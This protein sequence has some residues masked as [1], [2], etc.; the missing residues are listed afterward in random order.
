MSL[1]FL[2]NAC[3]A[4]F[5][6]NQTV[7]AINNVSHILVPELVVLEQNGNGN[8]AANGCEDGVGEPYAIFALGGDIGCGEA[9]GSND[10]GSQRGDNGRV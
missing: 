7:I 9:H 1:T 10:E 2:C 6:G 5:T 4:L 3:L 8:D